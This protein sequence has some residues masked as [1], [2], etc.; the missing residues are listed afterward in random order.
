MKKLLILFEKIEDSHVWQTSIEQRFENSS[1]SPICM[2]LHIFE[3]H[4]FSLT[5]KYFFLIYYSALKTFYMNLID[6]FTC[7]NLKGK[8]KTN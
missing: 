4:C 3:I 8:E 1:C 2:Y 7:W 6:K 5:L